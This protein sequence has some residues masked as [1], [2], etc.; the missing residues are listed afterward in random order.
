MYTKITRIIIIILFQLY[1]IWYYMSCV[2]GH[3]THTKANCSFDVLSN[4]L[5]RSADFYSEFR[6]IF[7]V[8]QNY[9][10]SKKQPPQCD[11]CYAILMVIILFY[12][13]RPKTQT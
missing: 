1:T 4:T 3:T 7:R 10:I 2:Q 12:C 8:R 11:A 6:P 5:W 13:I 9:R